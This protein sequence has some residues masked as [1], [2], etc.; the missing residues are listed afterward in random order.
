MVGFSTLGDLMLNNQKLTELELAYIFP[1]RH[2]SA[3]FFR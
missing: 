2:V 1:N 3:V